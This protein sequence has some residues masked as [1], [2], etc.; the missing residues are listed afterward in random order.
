VNSIQ[1]YIQKE[2]IFSAKQA[3]SSALTLMLPLASITGVPY[4][5]IWKDRFT[6]QTFREFAHS[7]QSWLGYGMPII[8]SV[9]IIGIVAHELIHGITWALF[10]KKGFKSIQFGM[11][12]KEITPYCHCSEPLKVKHYVAGTLMP[13]LLLG[14]VPTLAAYVTG[15]VWLMLFGMFFMAAAAGDFLIVKTLRTENPSTLIQDHPTAIG[16][17]IFRKLPG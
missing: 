12:W 7:S 9:M 14:I 3:N 8:I 16:Y 4:Y 6:F 5:L 2:V 11:L 17:Y 10:A 15:N 13:A 1:G